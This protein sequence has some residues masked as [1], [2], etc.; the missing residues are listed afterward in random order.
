MS[1]TTNETE[2]KSQIVQNNQSHK[3]RAYKT[4]LN[5]DFVSLKQSTDF[6]LEI[7]KSVKQHEGSHQVLTSLDFIQKILKNVNQDLGSTNPSKFKNARNGLRAL[8]RIFTIFELKKFSLKIFELT[9][10]YLSSICLISR[11]G[12]Y[13]TLKILLTCLRKNWK[14]DWVLKNDILLRINDG[15]RKL[16]FENKRGIKNILKMVKKL[17]FHFRKENR[18]RC[19]AGLVNFCGDLKDGSPYREIFEPIVMQ[20]PSVFEKEFMTVLQVL[21]PQQLDLVPKGDIILEKLVPEADEEEIVV[22][23]NK[24]F[25]GFFMNLLTKGNLNLPMIKYLLI[26]IKKF[27]PIWTKQKYHK[28]LVVDITDCI[29]S[30]MGTLALDG[31]TLAAVDRFLNYCEASRDPGYAN[32]MTSM[33]NPDYVIKMLIYNSILEKGQKDES[34]RANFRKLNMMKSLGDMVKVFS[35]WGNDGV[36]ESWYDSQGKLSVY[37]CFNC[38]KLENLELVF[39]SRT[40]KLLKKGHTKVLVNGSSLPEYK[41]LKSKIFKLGDQVFLVSLKAG[42]HDNILSIRDMRTGQIVFNKSFP[43]FTNF[44]IL[45]NKIFYYGRFSLSIIEFYETKGTRRLTPKVVFFKNFVN[46]LIEKI[47]PFDN[48]L[49]AVFPLIHPFIFLYDFRQNCY[50]KAELSEE[51][52]GFLD[53]KLD[54]FGDGFD[55]LVMN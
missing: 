28:N 29:Y 15:L 11:H 22:I 44:K 51:Q 24:K 50:L 13:L 23:F 26:F 16:K 12:L 18:Q 52:R 4:K 46:C 43:K 38:D 35:R 34:R 49:I 54:E 10:A 32:R 40:N 53:K 7:L 39:N 14:L 36:V 31:Q 55:Q 5:P 17:V 37:S 20:D 47:T 48:N 3:K 9:F 42:S 25:N 27:Q 41:K 45:E 6:S 8:N 21:E 30:N 19:L 33:K 2:T 1:D